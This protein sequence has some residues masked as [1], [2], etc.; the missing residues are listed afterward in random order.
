MAIRVTIEIADAGIPVE[1][2]ARHL[3]DC[4][5]RLASFMDF[6]RSECA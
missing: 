2:F 4:A 6:Y 1:Q 5:E 3:K